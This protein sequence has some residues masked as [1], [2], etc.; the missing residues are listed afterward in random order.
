MERFK[1]GYTL[2]ELKGRYASGEDKLKE[3]EFLGDDGLPYCKKCKTRRFW[4]LDEGDVCMHGACQ[5]MQ[6]AA[7]KER[8]E[9]EARKR[10]EEFNRQK[11]LSLTVSVLR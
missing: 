6:E 11:A 7:E 5:C 9:E 8:K 10:M 1:F 3:D 4:V 2:E